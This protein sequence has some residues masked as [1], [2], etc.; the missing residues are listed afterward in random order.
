MAHTALTHDS[1]RLVCSVGLALLGLAVLLPAAHASAYGEA[2]AAA[3]RPREPPPSYARQVHVQVDE[4]EW[5][6][7]ECASQTETRAA[8]VRLTVVVFPDGQW[9]ATLDPTRRLTAPGARGSTPL[10]R[11]FIGYLESALGAQLPAPPGPRRGARVTQ[12]YRL[13]V[14]ANASQARAIARAVQRHTEALTGCIPDRSLSPRVDYQLLPNGNLNVVYVD[15]V[16]E[17][18]FS[19]AL[20]CLRN[21]AANIRGLP[22]Y[23]TYTGSLT[24]APAPPPSPR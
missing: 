5:K 14:A 2:V 13:P 4:L 22:T 18:G 7:H 11:C 6:A 1:R 10:E 8:S 19:D 24:L 15:G 3:R 9:S 21:E 17:A 12:R 20:V 23:V 16:A